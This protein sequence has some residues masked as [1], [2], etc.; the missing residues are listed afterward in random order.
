PE[1][2]EQNDH[3]GLVGRQTADPVSIAH[4]SHQYSAAHGHGD[5][6]GESDAGV[7]CHRQQAPRQGVGRSPSPGPPALAPRGQPAFPDC[8]GGRSSVSPLAMTPE[9]EMHVMPP[10]SVAANGPQPDSRPAIRPGGKLSAESTPP[11]ESP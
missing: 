9:D 3:V 6:N 10:S 11:A 2:R 4:G 7:G 1:D 8:S 5:R